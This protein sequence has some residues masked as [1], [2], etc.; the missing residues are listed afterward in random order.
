MINKS[1]LNKMKIMKRKWSKTS[2]SQR[3]EWILRIIME[4]SLLHERK[5]K[6]W[7]KPGRKI[8]LGWLF[9]FYK[10]MILR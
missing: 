8:K 5:E 1:K 10:K 3:Q 9:L 4:K 7:F 6:K 2:K